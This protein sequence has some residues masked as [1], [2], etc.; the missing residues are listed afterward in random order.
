VRIAKAQVSLRSTP[1]PS[2]GPGRLHKVKPGENLFQIARQYGLDH[3]SLMALNGLSEDDKIFPGDSLL[4]SG[5]G[6]D[7]QRPSRPRREEDSQYYLVKSGDTL[8]DIAS[9]HRTTVQKLKELNGRIAKS[10]KAGA[11]IRVR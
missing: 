10:L 2:A 3:Q 1:A 4:V 6:R 5:Q 11:R 9:R 7:A 8:W